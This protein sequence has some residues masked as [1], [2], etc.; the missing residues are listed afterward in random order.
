MVQAL[1]VA[2]LEDGLGED[3]AVRLLGEAGLYEVHEVDRSSMAV[4]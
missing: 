4:R 3:Y 1:G 2:R